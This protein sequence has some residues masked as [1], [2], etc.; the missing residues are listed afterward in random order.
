MFVGLPPEKV[1]DRF[2]WR[3]G[4][5]IEPLPGMDSAR[6]TSPYE[7]RFLQVPR[8]E[9]FTRPISALKPDAC[10]ENRHVMKEHDDDTTLLQRS[11]R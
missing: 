10:V 2:L 8:A 9:A 5:A 4:S 7:R 3:V 6:T 1:L 11:F